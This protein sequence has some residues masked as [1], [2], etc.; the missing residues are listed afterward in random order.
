MLFISCEYI[1]VLQFFELNYIFHTRP[2]LFFC[3]FCFSNLKNSE[4]FLLSSTE[5]SED[6]VSYNIFPSHFMPKENKK[7]QTKW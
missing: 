1:H 4:F 6:N 5:Y 2:S 3:L 7:K